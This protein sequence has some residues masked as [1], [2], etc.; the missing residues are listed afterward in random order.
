MSNT[1]RHKK[2]QKKTKRN[3]N[4]F[5]NEKQKYGSCFTTEHLHKLKALWNTRHPDKHIKSN[6]PEIIHKSISKYL[7]NVCDDELC[8]IENHFT[9]PKI[10][11]QIKKEA[12]APVAQSSWKRKHNEWLD[13]ND[14]NA[15]MK[16]YEQAN[17]GFTFIG[18][19]P[20]DFDKKPYDNTCV[21]DDL[22]NLDISEKYN[23]GY[24]KIGM[25][26]NLDPHY[27]EGSHWVSMFVDLDK[28]FIFFLDS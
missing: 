28:N 16:Q 13:S 21:W 9:D 12:F 8:W 24:H 2:K 23:K 11:K 22:C 26:F 3:V 18:P 4:C 10:Q 25:I 14:I 6:K 17:G 20:I 19:S 27:K 7:S 15:V 1:K 5:A